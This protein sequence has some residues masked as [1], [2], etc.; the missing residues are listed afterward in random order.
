[1]VCSMIFHATH[2]SQSPTQQCI[3]S[4]CLVVRVA[5]K[6]PLSPKAQGVS[7]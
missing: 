2:P 3:R 6:R 4:T 5:V 1:M 7:V